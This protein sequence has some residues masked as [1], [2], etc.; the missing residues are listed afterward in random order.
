MALDVQLREYL[1]NTTDDAVRAVLN[2]YLM[3]SKRRE[4]K[5]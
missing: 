5:K 1:V 2:R 3:L 4:V